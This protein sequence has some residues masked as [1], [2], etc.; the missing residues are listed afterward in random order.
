MRIAVL[1]GKERIERPVELVAKL[2]PFQHGFLGVLP[3]CQTSDPQ[4][5][6]VR[7]VY[8]NS[9]AALAGIAAG[10]VLVSAN[11]KTVHSRVASWLRR[12]AKLEPGNELAVEFRRAWGESL[13]RKVMLSRADQDLPPADL[14]SA[15]KRDQG[16][17]TTDRRPSPT[18]AAGLQTPIAAP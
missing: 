8:P 7:F 5:V 17:R 18:P 15:I 9:P 2:E 6:A 4:G 10:D 12:S 16:F 11:G 1:R 14:P 13:R 3:L